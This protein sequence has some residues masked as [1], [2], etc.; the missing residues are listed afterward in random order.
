MPTGK[1]EY[2]ERGDCN[3]DRYYQDA[4]FTQKYADDY[5]IPVTGNTIIYIKETYKNGEPFV[6]L[7]LSSLIMLTIWRMSGATPQMV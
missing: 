1:N 3:Y 6:G 4:G 2:T 5:M 7:R